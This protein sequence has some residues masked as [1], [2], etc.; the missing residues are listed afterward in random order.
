MAATA[1]AP[2]TL[3]EDYDGDNLIMP[4]TALSLVAQQT[5]TTALFRVT[6]VFEEIDE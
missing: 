4:G 5:T 1:V 2:F 6:I 3:G